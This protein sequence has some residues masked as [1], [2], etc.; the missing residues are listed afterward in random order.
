MET[1]ITSLLL[2][3]LQYTNIVRYGESI[4][5]DYMFFL[6]L[7]EIFVVGPLSPKSGHFPT[8]KIYRILRIFSPSVRPN[9]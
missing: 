2:S 1:I 7:L 5:I 3:H 6:V 9:H 8:C 4:V